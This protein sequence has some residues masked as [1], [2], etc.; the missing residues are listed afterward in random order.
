VASAALFARSIG[1][2]L[3]WDDVPLAARS[4]TG[5]AGLK[6]ALFGS[7]WGSYGRLAGQSDFYRPVASL[8]LWLDRAFWGGRAAGFHLTNVLAASVGAAL[9]AVWMRRRCA[10]TRTAALGSLLFAVLPLRVESVAFVSDRTDLFCL[11]F[12]LLFLLLWPR[13]GEDV[14]PARLA[15]AGGSLLLAAG[16]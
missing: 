11:V 6:A 7:F 10:S 13:A 9:L 16:S 14:R 15:L 12:L 2:P 8:A 1:Y 4:L 3:L 5:L